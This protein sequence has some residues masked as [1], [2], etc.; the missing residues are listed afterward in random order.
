[1]WP[2]IYSLIF[3]N[4]NFLI[5]KMGFDLFNKFLLNVHFSVPDNILRT[6]DS[7]D[8]KTKSLSSWSLHSRGNMK[9]ICLVYDTIIPF[10]S[11][12]LPFLSL[13]F[14]VYNL[15]RLI[16]RI[17]YYLKCC[18]HVMYYF[19]RKKNLHSALGL[20]VCLSL[21]SF[22]KVIIWG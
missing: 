20:I 2:W 17:F 8:S 6:G 18:K 10:L 15:H 14:L 5:Y 1:M 4:L 9:Y 16:V 12:P 21:L 3:L 22:V 11:L 13:S 19:Y 7:V